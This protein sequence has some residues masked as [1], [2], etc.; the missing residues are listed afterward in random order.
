MD[1]LSLLDETPVDGTVLHGV[2]QAGGEEGKTI[3]QVPGHF[4]SSARVDGL[5]EQIVHTL[6]DLV[7]FHQVLLD[8][9]INV[10]HVRNESSRQLLLEVA[11]GFGVVDIC[12]EGVVCLPDFV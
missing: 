4:R 2:L 6:A 10:V 11:D 7:D 12:L 1:E 3:E 5:G 9:R 8:V